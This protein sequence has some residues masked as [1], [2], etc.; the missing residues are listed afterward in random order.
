M[1]HDVMDIVIIDEGVELEEIE[2][3]MQCCKQGP[4]PVKH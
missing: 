4:S 1:E 2:E 3:S